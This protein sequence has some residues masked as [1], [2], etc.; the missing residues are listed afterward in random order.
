MLDRVPNVKASVGCTYPR[1]NQK[2]QQSNLENFE[3]S[4][5]GSFNQSTGRGVARNMLS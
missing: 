5:D 2:P 3:E 1:E 4:D